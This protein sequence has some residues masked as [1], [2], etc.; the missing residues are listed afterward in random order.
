[1]EH[2]NGLK[3]MAC[4]SDPRLQPEIADYH[5]LPLH[6]PIIPPMSPTYPMIPPPGDK[7]RWYESLPPT[8]GVN[9][10][11]SPEWFSVSLSCVF[12]WL[13]SMCGF[14]LQHRTGEGRKTGRQLHFKSWVHVNEGLKQA[15]GLRVRFDVWWQL[16]FL[17]ILFLLFSDYT[18]SLTILSVLFILRFFSLFWLS[19]Y[20]SFYIQR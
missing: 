4:D 1:M 18:F 15:A 13:E 14:W 7:V 6:L 19:C 12:V 3:W 17:K 8:I 11:T 20:N 9:L 16:S 5:S 10:K 2:C